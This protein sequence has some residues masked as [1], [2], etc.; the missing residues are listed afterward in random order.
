MKIEALGSTSI[1]AVCSIVILALPGGVAAA[2]VEI[3]EAVYRSTLNYPPP[4]RYLFG[5]GGISVDE[6]WLTGSGAS[7]GHITASAGTAG[8]LAPF[9]AVSIHLTGTGVAANG[10]DAYAG[11]TYYWLVEQIAGAPRSSARVL[12]HVEGSVSEALGGDAS[13]SEYAL[14]NINFVGSNAI[15]VAGEGG[16]P[17]IPS[18]GESFDRTFTRLVPTN[19]V[20]STSLVASGIANAGWHGDAGSGR[21]DAFADPLIQIDPDWAFAD[22]FRVVFS[23][24]VGVI[25]E[26]AAVILWMAGLLVTWLFTSRQRDFGVA[27]SRLQGRSGHPIAGT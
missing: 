22:D 21:L 25:P 24:G 12:I 15:F 10:A 14:V 9:A 11:V 26:P 4:A 2:M 6:E 19:T 8:G 23:S 3:P 17:G 20:F 27:R 16:P 5:P 13:A 1:C 18:L 7:R